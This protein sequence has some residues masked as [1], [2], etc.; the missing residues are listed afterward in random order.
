MS[1]LNQEV[2]NYGL[3][4]GDRYF[5]Y[6]GYFERQKSSFFPKGLSVR[7]KYIHSLGSYTDSKQSGTRFIIP[8]H[9]AF[10]SSLLRKT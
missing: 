4:A 1:S 6:F 5:G 9:S 2:S 8:S 3:E 7:A 10:K